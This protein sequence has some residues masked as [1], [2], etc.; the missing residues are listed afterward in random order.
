MSVIVTINRLYNKC[1]YIRFKYPIESQRR[2]SKVLRMENVVCCT[3]F[4]T[5]EENLEI[6]YLG[7]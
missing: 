7:L 2:E 4:K 6:N 5:S 1:S 3:D